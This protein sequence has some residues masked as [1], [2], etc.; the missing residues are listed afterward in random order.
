MPTVCGSGGSSL[1][2][3]RAAVDQAIASAR[4]ALGGSKASLGFLF[5]SPRHDL[6]RALRAA[7]SRVPSLDWVLASTAGEATEHGPTKGGIAVMMVAWGDAAHRLGQAVPLASADLR[8]TAETLCSGYRSVVDDARTRNWKAA[9]SL[10]FGD[11]L[12]PQLEPLITQ[13]RRATHI[14]HTVLGGGAADDGALER[15]WV[16][17]NGS[18]VIEG[19]VAAVHVASHARWGV[20]IGQGVTAASDRMTVTRATRNVV[21]ELDGKPA[22]EVYRQHAQREGV[23]LTKENVAEYLLHHE[24]GIYFFDDIVRVRAGLATKPDDSVVFAGE[25]PEG[26]TVAF[27]R[28]EPEALIDAARRATEE[29]LR[30]VEG[31]PAGALLFSCI[32]R[33]LILKDRYG[34]ELDAVKSAL[35]KRVPIA[36]FLS[37]GEV[38]RVKGKL[39]GY[40]NNTLV[41]ALIPR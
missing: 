31:E 25:V 39:D 36:G 33:G 28:G 35:G 11:G 41:V 40:H 22:L 30:E 26:A 1:S 6:E 12:S 23:L 37:Y 9:A 3:T 29:A 5:A 27:V 19:G 15:S 13:I 8:R 16:G 20:G 17:S 24:L 38:A 7:C 32:T 34:E 14:H 18:G 2:D 4:G 10:V 21:H